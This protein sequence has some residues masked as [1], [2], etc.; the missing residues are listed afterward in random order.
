MRPHS[1]LHPVCL[2]IV[3]V[4]AVMPRVAH[5]DEVTDWNAVLIRAIQTAATAG[6][7][8]GRV[9]AI[10]HVAMFDAYNGV[11]R[12]YTPIRPRVRG[13]GPPRR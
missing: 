8:Q 13:S 6:P 2:L 9:A 12:R 5:A 1:L 4:L 7:L 3:C 10:V 11:E